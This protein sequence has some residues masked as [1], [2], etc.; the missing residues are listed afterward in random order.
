MDGLIFFF[1]YKELPSS[2]RD[3]EA[4]EERWGK[5]KTNQSVY[6]PFNA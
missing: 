5:K 3:T 4:E 1:F 6:N 2:L